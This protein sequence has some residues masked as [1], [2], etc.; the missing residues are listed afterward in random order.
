MDNV[1]LTLTHMP[2]IHNTLVNENAYKIETKLK[3]TVNIEM[4]V[5]LSFLGKS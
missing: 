3:T 4:L 1:H 2:N 5:T